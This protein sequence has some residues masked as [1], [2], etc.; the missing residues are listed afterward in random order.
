VIAAS[1]QAAPALSISITQEASGYVGVL[2]AAQ[3]GEAQRREVRGASCREVVDALAVVTVGSLG[4]E[5][6]APKEAGA[7]AAPEGEAPATPSPLV[8]RMPGE[9][10]VGAGKLRFERDF[11]TTLYA[12]AMSGLIPGVWVPRYELNLGVANVMISPEGGHYQMGP[13]IR[14]HGALIGEASARAVPGTTRVAGFMVGIEVCAPMYFHREGLQW[15][16]CPQFS[17]GQLQLRTT[18]AAGSEGPSKSVGLGLAGILTEV[19]YHF[20]P[21]VQ[22]ALKLGV[23]GLSGQISAEASD[24]SRIFSSSGLSVHGMLGLGGSF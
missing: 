24:G 19:S 1:P 2:R 9:L 17:T 6:A 12:G 10:S 5:N 18:N 15:L 14:V 7:P 21:H 3:A 11:S 13:L 20:G 4:P 8:A 16:V 23:D 22:A